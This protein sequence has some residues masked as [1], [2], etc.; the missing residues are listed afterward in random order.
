MQITDISIA[1]CTSTAQPSAFHS[2]TQYSILLM[3]ISRT[4]FRETHTVQK[5]EK[6]DFDTT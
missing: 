1:L 4:Q 3:E 2:L 5:N 6:Y